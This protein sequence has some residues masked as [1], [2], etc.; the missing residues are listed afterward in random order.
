MLIKAFLNL[1]LLSFTLILLT[2]NSCENK[3]ETIPEPIASEIDMLSYDFGGN[4][5]NMWSKVDSLQQIGLYKSA[6]DVVSVIFD[7]ASAAKNSPQVVKSVIHKMKYNSYMTED[8]YIVALNQLNKVSEKSTF[9]LKQIIHSVTAE[10]YWGYYQSNRWKF[11]NR[12]QTINFDNDDIR[13]WDLTTIIDKVYKQHQLA[14]SNKDS[15]QHTDIKDFDEMLT[16]YTDDNEQRPSLYDFLAH[17]A[18]DFFQNPEKNLTRP[19]DQFKLNGKE[20]FGSA[21]AFSNLS[22]ESNDTLSCELYEVR[23]LQELTKFHLSDEKPTA[24]IDL[25]LRRLKFTRTNSTETNKEELYFMALNKLSEKYS[26]CEANDEIQFLIAEYLNEKGNKYNSE[27][28][29]NQFEKKKAHEICSAVINKNPNSFGAGLC[30]SLLKEIQNKK[31]SFSMEPVYQPNTLGKFSLSTKNI[32]SLYFR[33][34]KIDW[35]YFLTENK[36]GK[37]LMNSFLQK[38]TVKSWSKQIKNFGDFQLHSTEL[39]LE[40]LPK[41]QYVILASPDKNF[42]IKNNAIAYGSFWSSNLS[43][44]YRKNDDE[45]FD[46]TVLDRETGTP[47]KGAKVQLYIRKYNRSTRIYDIIKEE[48]Y[49]TNEN[50]H[51]NIKSAKQ[52]RYLYLDVPTSQF[53]SI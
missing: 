36:Y 9:P 14:I 53:K 48:S 6:L 52:Y 40:E 25:E 27:T 23:I 3:I 10:T 45:T 38:E 44:I 42:T 46:V 16:S 11:I 17:R 35:N 22:T 18:L 24:L 19:A 26:E 31:I 41:G 8:E 15:L 34:I 30:K 47:I 37:E 7:S 51:L 39:K 29:E 21:E 28:K 13:T 12:T 33:I 2:S 5:E 20:Y 32:D 4:F 49:T 43:Y 1:T 50:G